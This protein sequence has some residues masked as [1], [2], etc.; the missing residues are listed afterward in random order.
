MPASSWG[1]PNPSWITALVGS[2]HA[3]SGAAVLPG[4]QQPEAAGVSSAVPAAEATTAS[5]GVA[6]VDGVRLADST[7][8]EVYEC[9]EG[10]LGAH[11]KPEVR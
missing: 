7:R 11:L 4:T 5:K 3:G 2:I 8:Y 1:R 10:P 9:F 6:R